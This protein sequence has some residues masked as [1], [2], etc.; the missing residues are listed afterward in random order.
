MAPT[1]G[2]S[3]CSAGS[4]TG[5]LAACGASR[6]ASMGFDCP[7]P[8]IKTTAASVAAAATRTNPFRTIVGKFI[9]PE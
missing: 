5:L 3:G 9:P 4:S 6:P 2:L 1:G 8:A 7:Q